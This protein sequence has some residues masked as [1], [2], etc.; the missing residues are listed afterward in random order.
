MG[1]HVRGVDV[2]SPLS[3]ATIVGIVFSLS[4]A[5]AM[6]NALNEFA[7]VNIDRV[8]KPYRKVVSGKLERDE[9]I[10]VAIF[11]MIISVAV[12]VIINRLFGLLVILISLFAMMYSLKPFRL[13]RFLGIGNLSI[14]TPR[15]FLGVYSAW[16]AVGGGLADHRILMFGLLLGIYVYFSNITKDIPDVEGDKADG[17]RTFP[18]VYGI[19]KASRISS[20]GYIIPVILL[21][22]AVA[23]GY[24][25]LKYLWLSV[26]LPIFGYQIYLLW[27]DP[28]KKG[29]GENTLVWTLFY[30][31]FSLLFATYFIITVI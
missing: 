6:G 9:V 24:I 31:I 25:S 12:A 1:L 7:D 18:V 10:G 2:F 28:M 19:S 30:V 11:T 3:L 20:L 29:R 27:T 14:A 22:I 26:L 8:S 16:V 17:I 4:S 13:K 5:N 15:G 23:I 21:Y